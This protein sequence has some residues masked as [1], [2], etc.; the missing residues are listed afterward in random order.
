M[1]TETIA[2]PKNAARF[3]ETVRARAPRGFSEA[4]KQAAQANQLSTSE[5]VRRA[6]ARA[7]EP[8]TTEGRS[9]ASSQDIRASERMHGEFARVR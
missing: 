1:Q 9:D 2:H 7:I 3:I 5:F 6:V 4:V 8:P